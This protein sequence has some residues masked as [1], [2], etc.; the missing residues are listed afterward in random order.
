MKCARRVIPIHWED[1]SL[2][3]TRPLQAL[4]L[5]IDDFDTS[6]AFLAVRGPGVDLKLAPAW[7]LIYPWEGW[8]SP[9]AA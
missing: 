5:L 8:A 4:S 9:N 1:F 7:T 3:L 6:M 2:P